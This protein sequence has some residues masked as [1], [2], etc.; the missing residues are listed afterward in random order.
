MK[1]VN[2][3]PELESFLRREKCLK[4][5]KAN[6]N[7]SP[8]ERIWTIASAFVWGTTTEGHEFWKNLNGKFHKEQNEKV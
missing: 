1:K 6:V 8:E 4:K 7:V 2:L 3:T 5:F